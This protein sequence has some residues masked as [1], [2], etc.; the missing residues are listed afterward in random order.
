V[1]A[2]L[3]TAGRVDARPSCRRV[4]SDSADELAARTGRLTVA[5]TVLAVAALALITY[6]GGLALLA[7]SQG[8]MP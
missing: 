3:P 5:A 6:P 2:Q 7:A 8:V 1:T 4:L